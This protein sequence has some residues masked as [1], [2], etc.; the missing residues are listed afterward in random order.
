MTTDTEIEVPCKFEFYF[1]DDPMYVYI[2]IWRVIF[3]WVTTHCTHKAI[4]MPVRCKNNVLPVLKQLK[5]EVE[6]EFPCVCR[7]KVTVLLLA[8]PKGNKPMQL[9]TSKTSIWFCWLLCRCRQNSVEMCSK[10]SCL[11]SLKMREC[12]L[13]HTQQFFFCFWRRHRYGQSWCRVIVLSWAFITFTAYSSP[14]NTIYCKT[15]FGQACVAKYV[16]FSLL[17]LERRSCDCTGASRCIPPASRHGLAK[18]STFRYGSLQVPTGVFVAGLWSHE[19][20]VKR[21]GE[22][23]IMIITLISSRQGD[24]T[25]AM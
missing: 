15:L 19:G 2:K 1:D 18:T 8:N 7:P 21:V 22:E 14:S 17:V 10:W 6:T 9:L 3:V 23:R 25:M 12:M 11:S 4:S 13:S 20:S 5:K 16:G 24:A